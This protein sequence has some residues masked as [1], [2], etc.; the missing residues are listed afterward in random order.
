MHKT[1]IKN[2]TD[3]CF[4]RRL[5][6]TFLGK[7]DGAFHPDLISRA[8]DGQTIEIEREQLVGDHWI[9]KAEIV[10]DDLFRLDAVLPRELQ[11][12]HAALNERQHI[13]R[14][15]FDFLVGNAD[16]TTRVGRHV[17][18]RVADAMKTFALQN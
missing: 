8:V 17:V 7:L 2:L 13:A 4:F 3:G 15:G 14:I 9:F 18:A 12:A 11:T 10:G 16:A 1:E 6:E 5:A